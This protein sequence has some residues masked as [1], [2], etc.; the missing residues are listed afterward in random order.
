MSDGDDD[1][2]AVMYLL[3]MAPARLWG[4]ACRKN[5]VLH[6]FHTPGADETRLHWNMPETHLIDLPVSAWKFGIW[7]GAVLHDRNQ[8]A[9]ALRQQVVWRQAFLL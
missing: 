2:P 3:R 5:G 9:G 6:K 7:N 8:N 4:F 1:D